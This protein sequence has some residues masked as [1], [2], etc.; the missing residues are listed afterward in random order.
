MWPTAAA[1]CCS[2]VTWCIGGACFVTRLT[3]WCTLGLAS[4]ETREACRERLVRFVQFEL[5]LSHYTTTSYCLHL[6]VGME[7]FWP[8][9]AKGAKE[10]GQF[11][12]VWMG[13]FENQNDSQSLAPIPR[14]VKSLTQ[15]FVATS[16]LAPPWAEVS[17]ALLS[18]TINYIQC[19]VTSYIQ[20]CFIWPKSKSKKLSILSLTVFLLSL[21]FFYLLCPSNTILWNFSSSC[22][23]LAPLDDFVS[24]KFSGTER[25]TPPPYILTPQKLH[26]IL[27]GNFS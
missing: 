15:H 17:T 16:K 8:Q 7:T 3:P 23:V 1:S 20:H 27:C 25:Y 22:E 2:W 18:R 5:K 24:Q 10:P 9:V 19:Y 21:T 14:T 12:P 11:I 4:P 26:Q 6:H 13:H